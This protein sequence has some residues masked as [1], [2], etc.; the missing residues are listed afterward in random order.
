MNV[1]LIKIIIKDAI[2][3]GFMSDT[4]SIYP[5]TSNDKVRIDDRLKKF[6]YGWFLHSVYVGESVDI[7]GHS[8]SD[9][10]V[11]K[12]FEVVKKPGD[13]FFR[14]D[15]RD[16]EIGLT[17]WGWWPGYD[18]E[19]EVNLFIRGK[20]V[21]SGKDKVSAEI[22][23]CGGAEMELYHNKKLVTNFTKRDWFSLKPA[24]KIWVDDMASNSIQ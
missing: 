3:A 21:L 10:S 5:F 2:A 22:L 7:P 17:L 15:E 18:H 4:F 1:I 6:T 11:V 19:V 20:D 12:Y 16:N 14:T 8:D 23:K 9:F 24:D 13:P